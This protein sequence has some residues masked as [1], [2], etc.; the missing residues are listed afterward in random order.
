MST[1]QRKYAMFGGLFGFLYLLGGSVLPDF[2]MGVL[3]GVGI[4]CFV[5]AL[6][7]EKTTKKVRKWK[8]RGK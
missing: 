7:P 4:L 1:Q 3:L 5:L 6:L 2:L 8:R